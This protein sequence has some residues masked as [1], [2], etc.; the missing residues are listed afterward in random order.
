MSADANKAIVARV[1]EDLYSQGQVSVV[2]EIMAEDYLNHDLLPGE[3]PSA[4]GVRQYVV[5]LRSAFPDLKF[6]VERMVAKDDFVVTR[7]L[8][9]GT[10]QG[11]FLAIPATGARMSATGMTM[12]RLENGRIVE[13]WTNWDALALLT[14]LGVLP[15]P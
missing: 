6:V 12:H 1:W 11:D 7:W 9:T 15:P 14:Q 5:T 13:G 8:A 3:E 4:E 10:H 2:D